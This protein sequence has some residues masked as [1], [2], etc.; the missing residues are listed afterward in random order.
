MDIIE[1]VVSIKIASDDEK[2]IELVWV[3]ECKKALAFNIVEHNLL[4][5]KIAIYGKIRG[6]DIASWSCN[7]C[8]K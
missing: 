8:I 1:G 3:S 4:L 2:L 7:K 5:T 6:R